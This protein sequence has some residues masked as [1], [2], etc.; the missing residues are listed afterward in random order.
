MSLFS[1]FELSLVL[2]RIMAEILLRRP[3][4]M[5]EDREGMKKGQ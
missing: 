4:H 2:Y 3:R 5:K 1:K